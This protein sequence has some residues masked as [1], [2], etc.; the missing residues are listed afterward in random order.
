[1][2]TKQPK[3][4]LFSKTASPKESISLAIHAWLS[5]AFP[6]SVEDMC[7]SPDYEKAFDKAIKGFHKTALE[8]VSTVWIIKNVS[9]AFQ[10]Q[11]TRTRLAGYSIQSLR[12][13]AKRGF[14]SNGHYT[15]PPGYD[16]RQQEAFHDTML[17]IEREYEALLV[18][19]M[20]MEDARGILPLN[21]HSDISMVINL[22]SLFDMLNKRFCVLVQWEYRQ[23]ASQMR[24][25]IERE[26]GPEFIQKL[27][28]P[29]VAARKCP[30][31]DD[32]C[33]TPVWK[34]DSS[35]RVEFYKSFVGN[36]GERK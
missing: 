16:E 1:M 13:V 20:L 30:M 18:D 26:F 29:C 5:D 10:Q 27:D 32:Y 8:F 9:R 31:R 7:E 12:G 19:G 34:L 25:V 4:I 33:G 22:S 35:Q 21:V 6:E 24:E 11:L 28:A 15:M 3:V 23:V 2:R 17:N 36:P 14:A